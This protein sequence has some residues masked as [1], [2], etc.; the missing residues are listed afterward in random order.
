MMHNIQFDNATPISPVSA[1][2]LRRLI[3]SCEAF[4]T[5]GTNL[6]HL[7]Q[8][9]F[10]RAA[11]VAVQ[12]PGSGCPEG[13][14]TRL[15]EPAS[16]DMCLEEY[17]HLSIRPAFWFRKSEECPDCTQST[18]RSPEEAGFGAPVPGGRV[19]HVRSKDICDHAGDVV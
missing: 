6:L 5:S 18:R 3:F 13:F 17:V 15:S 12:I 4:R 16:T 19:E 11:S 14:H 7:L 10:G 9:N 8:S 2:T 1:W